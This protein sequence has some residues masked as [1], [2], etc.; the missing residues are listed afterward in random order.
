VADEDR[1][2]EKPR[3]HLH[4]PANPIL[5]ASSREKIHEHAARVGM[6]A[7]EIFEVADTVFVRPDPE[8]VAA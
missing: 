4:A 7:T 1:A 3:V 8:A 5:E 6:P 2:G